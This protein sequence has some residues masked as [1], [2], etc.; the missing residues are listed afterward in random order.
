MRDDVR[1]VIVV[2]AVGWCL[3]AVGR[4]M[5]ADIG[6]RMSR[7]G[8]WT[9]SVC[10]YHQLRARMVTSVAVAVGHLRWLCGCCRRARGCVAMRDD[11]G[12]VIVVLSVERGLLADI[13][14]RVSGCGLWTVS[15]GTC[16]GLRAHVMMSAAGVAA[17][18]F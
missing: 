7:C 4:G 15:G 12:M 8:L 16:L 6:R 17:R 18:R 3:L 9:V 5:P 11:L 13:G 1:M 2:L 10:T 14:R